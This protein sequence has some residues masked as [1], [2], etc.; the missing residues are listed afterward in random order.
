VIA[1]NG[2]ETV[3]LASEAIDADR[4][5]TAADV[6]ERAGVDLVR[7]SMAVRLVSVPIPAQSDARWNVSSV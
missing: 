6:C 4:L 2:I 3:V 5:R 1:E 7:F